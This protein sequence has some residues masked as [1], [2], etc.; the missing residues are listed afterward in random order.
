[1]EIEIVR[2]AIRHNIPV[3][4]I[5]RG[6][7]ILNVALGGTLI[8]D[9]PSQLKE[10]IQHSQKVERHRDTHLVKVSE[11]SKLFQILGS[12]QI[13]VNSLHHQAIDMVAMD[14]R[15]VAS[16]SDGI[17]EAVE[18]IGSSTFTVGVQWHPESMA[19][20]NNSMN[21]LFIQFIKSCSG[22]LV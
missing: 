14:L 20:T 4:A 21:N 6:V 19:S 12:D 16:S 2:Y 3:L 15:V 11:D 8:Q 1:V 7:Q 22:V 10:P 17:I 5:C 18:Y 13:R 9:I